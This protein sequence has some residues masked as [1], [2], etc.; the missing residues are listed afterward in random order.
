MNNSLLVIHADLTEKG[1]LNVSNGSQVAQCSTF[2]M[3][4]RT[5]C[6]DA[7]KETRI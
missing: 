5:Q 1:I 6:W 4:Y 7:I 3:K 2:N